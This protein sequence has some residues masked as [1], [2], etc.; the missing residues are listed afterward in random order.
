[1]SK[2]IVALNQAILP[3]IAHVMR[4]QKFYLRPLLLFFLLLGQGVHLFAMSGAGIERKRKFSSSSSSSSSSDAVGGADAAKVT[5]SYYNSQRKSGLYDPAGAT[6]KLSRAKLENFVQCP[7]CFYLDR[8][9]GTAT[10]PGYPFSLNSAVDELFK[11]EFDGYR[12]R[13]QV[14]P[15]CEQAGLDAVPF[16]HPDIETWR[17]AL[18]A[19]LQSNIEGTN[20]VLQGGID[21]IW[22]DRTTGKLIIADYKAT[23]KK[24][25]VSLD[26]D[27][28]DGYKRQVEVYQYLLRKQGY[29]VSDTAYFVYANGISQAPSFDDT[30]R[31]ATTLLPYE[32]NA[33]WVEPTVVAAYAC[34]Q[35]DQIPS[36][37]RAQECAARCQMCRYVAARVRHVAQDAT[38]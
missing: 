35:S 7:T 9:L 23:S 25:Q 37:A 28:Q 32:G 8:R 11:K 13:Q 6:F 5:T 27:W 3:K 30:L 29:D 36:D 26:A 15:L 10:P 21:D 33:S 22:L 12:A 20:I 38:A 17:D 1:M 14:H 4:S 34:L 2:E 16:N 19:G 24:G 18:R 31:F